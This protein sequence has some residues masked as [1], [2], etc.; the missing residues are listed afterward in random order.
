MMSE[1]VVEIDAPA[2]VV[3]AVYSDVV[4]W[5]E[6]T[7]SVRSV[8]PL[9]GSGLEPGRRFRI[10]QPR[11]PRL[12]WTVTDVQPGASWA[13]EQRSPLSTAIAGHE[14]VALGDGRTRARLWVEQRGPIGVLVGWLFARR[15]RRYLAMEAK[16]L[17]AASFGRA[18]DGAQT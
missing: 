18:G 4:R 5:P 15:T 2:A 3:W 14:V 8:E 12:V 9:D 7:A 1:R 17:E 10:A 16:G 13:W 6:W 11:M